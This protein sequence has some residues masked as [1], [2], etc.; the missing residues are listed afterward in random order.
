MNVFEDSGRTIQLAFEGGQRIAHAM[1][2]GPTQLVSR[3]KG[4]LRVVRH[5]PGRQANPRSGGHRRG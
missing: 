4:R 5:H 2:A 3:F 1:M